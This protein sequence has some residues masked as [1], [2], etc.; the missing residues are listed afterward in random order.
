MN[1]NNRLSWLGVIFLFLPPIISIGVIHFAA[2]FEELT[3][4]TLTFF[5]Y[6]LFLYRFSPWN[7]HS[8]YKEH[9]E[10][11]L[12]ER[13]YYF[14]SKGYEIRNSW[15]VIKAPQYLK[16]EK[17]NPSF[18]NALS[19]SAIEYSI[20]NPNSRDIHISSYY[21]IPFSFSP[22][23]YFPFTSI[24]ASSVKVKPH[25]L[26]CLTSYNSNIEEIVFPTDTPLEFYFDFC[27]NL[28]RLVL[29]STVPPAISFYHHDEP[30][31]VRCHPDI[32]LYVPYESLKKYQE[33]L[34]YK[35]ITVKYADGT[36]SPIPIKPIEI[37]EGAE[38]LEDFDE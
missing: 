8:T 29:K 24:D 17:I 28:Q 32:A 6:F 25:E 36:I 5:L 1:K 23:L 10:K 15:I 35:K 2:R 27:C 13:A 34:A 18:V 11:S 7:K 30:S 4:V 26:E 31:I 19:D 9:S 37:P 38:Y 3:T 14:Y 22:Y 33:N 21:P 16:K 20:Q 12:F